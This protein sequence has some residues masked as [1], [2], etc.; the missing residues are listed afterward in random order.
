MFSSMKLCGF[1]PPTSVS[2]PEIEITLEVQGSS[3]LAPYISGRLF[4][5]CLPDPPAPW[6]VSGCAAPFH[7]RRPWLR[8]RNQYASTRRT[9]RW[10]SNRRSP[11]ATYHRLRS[12]Q[13]RSLS[14]W[15]PRWLLRNPLPPPHIV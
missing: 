14:S 15:E 12:S 9:T 2:T 11:P 4:T 8:R 13:L 1:A 7:R 5:K 3:Q 6:H 10:N